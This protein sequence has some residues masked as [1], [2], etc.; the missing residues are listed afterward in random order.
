M[1][2]ATISPYDPQA[3]LV[4]AFLT[5]RLPA[6][7]GI[8]LFGSRAKGEER[9]DSD[10]DFAFLQEWGHAP[11]PLER[12][13]L[14]NELAQLLGGP[15]VD[16]ID[17]Q[18]ADTDLRFVILS[19]AERI[20]CSDVYYCDFFELTAYSMYQRLELERRDIVEDVKKRGYI[21]GKD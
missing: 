21:Y 12:L 5:Q 2:K 20:H 1:D 6:L 15:D 16:L 9:P 19:T 17:L 14:A 4:T 18:T 3:S 7:K 8:Y 10:Y 13:Q 11:S